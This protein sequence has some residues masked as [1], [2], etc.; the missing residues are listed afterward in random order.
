MVETI[1][2][3]HEDTI[4]FRSFLLSGGEC[5]GGGGRFAFDGEIEASLGLFVDFDKLAVVVSRIGA[6]LGSKP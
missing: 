3:G 6:L 2:G 1:S 5:T 4:G